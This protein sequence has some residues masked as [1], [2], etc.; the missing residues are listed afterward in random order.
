LRKYFPEDLRTKKEVEFLYLKRENRSVAKYAAKFEELSRFFP[1]I[2]VEDAMV[3]K[4]VKFESGLRPDI[5]QYMCIQEIRD[6]DTLHKCRMFDVAGR[7]RANH[8]KAQ[9]DKKGMGHGFGKSYNR[10]EAGHKAFE[11]KMEITC[12]NCGET[13]HLSTKCTKP[14]KAVGKVFALNTEEVEKPDNL[15]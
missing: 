10:G 9:H 14:K 7:D 5:Y 1:Y 4:C 6:F 13:G 15:I 12:Y 3:S 8:Y 2:N 11:C